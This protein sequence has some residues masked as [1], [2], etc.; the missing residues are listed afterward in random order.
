M[1]RVL[2]QAE[3]AAT[4]SAESATTGYLWF[5][6]EI[7]LWLLQ[8]ALQ[9]LRPITSLPFSKPTTG[10]W[11]CL[12]ALIVAHTPFTYLNPCLLVTPGD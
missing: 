8:A 11:C 9:L 4:A 5:P 6:E 3:S 12:D 7:E 2:M 1:F 10:M